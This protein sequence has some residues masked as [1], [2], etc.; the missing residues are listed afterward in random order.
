MI[1]T[2][3]SNIDLIQGVIGYGNATEGITDWRIENT[4][5][6]IFNINNSSSIIRPS[7]GTT[8]I[9]QI[10]NSSDR[11]MIFKEGTSTF[12]VPAGGIVCDILV[13][14]GG[15]SGGAFGG[16]GGGGGDVIYQQN[17][18]FPAGTYNINVG[19]GGTSTTGND[20]GNNGANSSISGTG[21]TT[22]TAVGGG[23]GA[24]YNQSSIA[25]ATIGTSSGGGGGGTGQNPNT[26][27]A[28]SQYSG[29]GGNG[30]SSFLTT[31]G[32]GGGSV[33]VGGTAT[34]KSKAGNGGIGNDISIIGIS[35]QYGGGGG[36]GNWAGEFTYTA[37]NIGGGTG[38]YGGG[39]GAYTANSTNYPAINGTPNTGGGGGGGGG[40]TAGGIG[41]S[42][43]VIIRYTTTNISI[44]DNGNI[45]IGTT[46]ISSSSKLEIFGDVNI[47][48][49]YR[50]NNSNVINDTSNY[51]L[52]TSNLLV[53]R[54]I[55]E[56]GHGSNYVN[57]IATQIN[58]S[59]DDTSNYVAITSSLLANRVGSQWANISSGIHYTPITSSFSITSS[60]IATT[61][62]TTGDYTYMA[63][64]YTTETAGAGTGQ[65][66]YTINVPTGGMI[67]DV[68]VVGGGGSGGRSGGGGGT[69]IYSQNIY[70][71]SGGYSIKVGNGAISVKSGSTVYEGIDGKSSDID[72]NSTTI[73]RA[74]GGGGGGKNDFV[75][76]RTGGSSGGGEYSSAAPTSL[77]IISTNTSSSSFTTLTN[78]S[79]NGLTIYGNTGGIG[80]EI[81]GNYMGGGGGGAGGAGGNGN[82]LRSGAG[83]VGIYNSIT[84]SD[85]IYGS[86]GS[87]G[88]F[89]QVF[90]SALVLPGAVTSGGGTGAYNTNA[91]GTG[92]AVGA[93]IA[94]RGGGGGGWTISGSVQFYAGD[95]GSGIVII[96]FLS[97]T[98]N[99]GIGTTNP[100]SELHV[101]DDTTTNTKLTIQNNFVDPIVIY[102][103]TVQSSVLPEPLFT[104]NPTGVSSGIIDG[105]ERY[106][107]FT[108]TGGYNTNTGY[109]NVPIPKGI[110][111]DL[112][113]IG[114]GGAGGGI[115]GSGGGS[116]ACLVAI[117][118]TLPAGTYTF[119]VGGAGSGGIT[120]SGNSGYDTFI[121]NNLYKA[122]GGGG[123][124]AD[125]KNGIVGGCSG[126]AAGG[127]TNVV[128]T[129]PSPSTDNYYQ[130]QAS[131]PIVNT[132]L[133]YS[134]YAN[135]GGDVTATGDYDTIN[136][137]GG[138]GI[139]AAAAN[140][141]TTTRATPGGDGLYQVT[142]SGT[143]YNLRTY[144]TNNG[145]FGVQDGTTGY[146]FIGGG[147]GA[148]G[149]S[150]FSSSGRATAEIAG[151][152]GG[153]GIGKN[154][155]YP[156]N[157]TDGFP[158]T[159][160]GGGGG[161]TG[162][163][164]NSYGGN[165][166]SGLL[167]IR[168]R[169]IVGYRVTET[170]ESNKFYKTITFNYFPNYPED[171]PN[172]ALLAWYRFDGDGID[173]NPYAT[174]YNLIANVGTPTYSSGTTADSFFQGRRYINTGG[175][176]LKNTSLSLNSRAFSIALWVRKKNSSVALFIAQS[177]SLGTNTSLHIGQ[178]ENNVYTIDFYGNGLNSALSYPEDINIWAHIVYV[179]LPN[180]N[181][182]IYRNGVLIAT[183][184]NGSAFSG[185]GD[186]RIGARNDNNENQNVDI[187]DFRIYNN[188]LSA[189]EVATLYASY[190]NLVIT[191]NYSVNFKS[192]TTLLV[193]GTSKTVDGTY[194]LSMGHL[195]D[196]MLPASGQS[197]IPLASTVLTSLPIKYEYSNTAF[198]LPSLITVVG[199]TS[200]FI[201]TTER[202]L[203]FT[204]T[205]DNYGLTGQTMYTFTPTED[206]W[207]DILI[208]GGGGGGGCFGG[209]GGGGGVLFGA[210]LKLNGGNAVTVKVGD[211]G[212]GATTPN[213]GINGLDGYN[214]SIIINSIEYI[215]AGGGGG[216]SRN[217][218]PYNG[219]NGNNGGS[220][221][222]G[223][224]G[225][226][227][228]QGLGGISN[229][230]NYAN[231]QSFGNNGGIGKFGTGGSPGWAS[232]GGGGA[233]SKGSDFSTTT[234]G[235]NG[236]QGKDFISYF[237]TNVGHYGF[238]A[239]GGGGNTY[240][241]AGNRG[242]GNGGLGLY[243]GGGNAGY[244][245]ILEYSADNGLVNTGGGG[246]GGK[247]DEITSGSLSGGKGGS[248]F[249]IIRYRRFTTQS[250]SLEL[251]TSGL[252]SQTSTQANV[253]DPIVSYSTSTYTYSQLLVQKAEQ[254]TGVKG[255][256]H[257]KHL[258]AGSTTW[259]RGN[260]N[261]QGNFEY[262]Q[263][264]KLENQ[265]WAIK[266]NDSEM[267]E[268]L[269][270]KG[271]DISQW[272][273]V[274]SSDLDRLGW[275][276][277]SQSINN[278]HDPYKQYNYYR[279]E[280]QWTS[281]PYIFDRVCNYT[282]V[283]S[284]NY[285]IYQEHGESGYGG[286]GKSWPN[287]NTDFNPRNFHYD[288]FVRRPISIQSLVPNINPIQFSSD[289]KYFYFTHSGESETQTSYTINFPEN[290]L[291][292]IL[293][294][295]GGGG[296]GGRNAGGGGAG[297]LVLV[298]NIILFGNFT[299]NVGRGGLGRVG[300]NPGLPGINST[301][302]KSDNL[303]IITANGGGGGGNTNVDGGN[304]GSGGG[305]GF[306]RTNGTQ[307]QKSQ[308]Q[309][310]I[311]SPS[312]LNQYGE[313]G[314]HGGGGT[315]SYPGGGGGGAGGVGAT[316]GG[317]ETGQ[318][319]G[320][321][322]DRVGDF[323][324][325]EKFNSSVGDYGW[326]AGGGGSAGGYANTN[327]AYGNGGAS[328]FGG[329]GNGD[330]VG[331]G[332]NGISGT[333][334]G[335]GGIRY[336]DTVPAGNGGSG[337]V[338]IRYRSTKIG[339]QG[340]NIGNYNGDFKI[341]SSTYLSNSQDTDFMR[342]TRDGASI[343]NPTG[344]P[345]WSTVSDR[346]IKENIEKA[347]YDK[348]YES[349][350]KLELYRF[351]YIKE[352]NN[353]N[354]DLKQ[355]GYIAQEVKDIFPKA[356]SS[357]EFYNE[358]L[359]ISDMLSIDV[360][361][362][363][364]SLYGAV[365][366]LMEMYSDKKERLQKLKYLLNISDSYAIDTSNLLDTTSNISINTSNLLDTTSN[367][368]ID[369]GNIS[370]NTSNISIDT[371]NISID[372]SNI[373]IDTSN[374][375]IDTSNISIDTSNISIDTS[376]ISIDTSNISID[377]SNISIDT[378]NISID[379]SNISI[380]TS[381]ISI[382]TSNISIDT[383]NISIDTSN[384][385]IDTSNISIDTSN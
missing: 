358:N 319:G 353:I 232:G 120:G 328:M 7:G 253:I 349:I 261:L 184:A 348:C 294:V 343:Y 182:R 51:I 280:E 310:G 169:N 15:G 278:S 165:G 166:G 114:G 332:I 376:N 144:F 250:A 382:D 378:S 385:S 96:R 93:T 17:I 231:F 362:I 242:Y 146:Y 323:I 277:S 222:G 194:T 152:K 137:G 307:T 91:S 57:R 201:G 162:L 260:D 289:Y 3:Y 275:Q 256:V 350:N 47:S 249:V 171:P 262:N 236:G 360:T 367:I 219:K 341:V 292:D 11:Y 283:I 247:Y 331:R 122:R 190:T 6:G 342:I 233:G 139:G 124:A 49:N 226:S 303:I 100:T 130:S 23:G 138:G 132:S 157:G 356:V 26:A 312:I 81:G 119:V 302:T 279:S 370:I 322:I 141:N 163:N 79:P 25:V 318:N 355:L 10:T 208:V 59:I 66:L 112:L 266:W 140:A 82:S 101:Y 229:K 149:F 288:V 228:I 243:G 383:S 97:S 214:S 314:G 263:T 98:R 284:A 4:G 296:G 110:T 154:S 335:G 285:M 37:P 40:I 21:I 309:I 38:V 326:F 39:D 150:G 224:T 8:E 304:G 207:C 366:K 255:W 67:C 359:S 113:M 268:V 50:K 220:G 84:G 155:Y 13:V 72:Y 316:S 136:Y 239:G 28:T 218:S 308:S 80:F 227:S 257:V 135:K 175:G 44:I 53:P 375:S 206:L 75:T 167:I 76:G 52:T 83:G 183:D 180:Y 369:T 43:I 45:G 251:I 32:G 170:L 142:L 12:T 354:K 153:G 315:G 368:S 186:L 164:G 134:I 173:Y 381:N 320:L 274:N 94:G 158:N 321:G 344:T 324:F 244:D 317:D 108:H 306:I 85:I 19:S 264:T 357:Q 73:F 377:T 300:D 126:G 123:G 241:N 121:G 345:L 174:K 270:T 282:D 177:A 196:S 287:A 74:R 193:N 106:Y 145:T 5:A 62:G 327:Y 373:S 107:I 252:I 333:G 133:S 209:G 41:G 36:G 103:N 273:H 14:G 29:A 159:G 235:G 248:G 204:Y 9:G 290:T 286:V 69:V 202:G 189:T 118:Q 156:A 365:K 281:S 195:N 221:G 33:G 234:G 340:Y 259:Y 295:A 1:I 325:K 87:S 131:G 65:S 42:G 95:G 352:L 99:V 128:Y 210:N 86:G 203:S 71:P 338:I 311:I 161:S 125:A 77:N 70:F 272:L 168:Y 245:G 271:S 117:N 230:N 191:D 92:V 105:T 384:I 192:P 46:P 237:G 151:G 299:I 2:S 78:Q 380:D 197:D 64:T 212:T 27:G 30:V 200:S 111:F 301:F 336:S 143:Q 372:T 31:S 225:E 181:R 371:S 254:V 48:T 379:T 276:N 185:S 330:G 265:E 346:R 267:K 223:S 61:V 20:R 213:S 109:A 129:S 16:G 199:T 361:Q 258:P 115:G 179:V 240:I 127:V 172:T 54:I 246:G 305:G 178:R 60:P 298:Q 364:Y 18:S 104:T 22:I 116:G 55:T 34:I 269:F 102:P 89:N 63:F 56:V 35:Q 291:C 24:G 334:G 329:G 215:A 188:G 58:T 297:G 339:Y 313:N 216:G 363:N 176:S 68:L 90:G 88:V 211:G 187:S 293:L 347:S 147:G 374:I 337:I 198:S 238:F 217:N 160:S 148:G 205:S 351:S